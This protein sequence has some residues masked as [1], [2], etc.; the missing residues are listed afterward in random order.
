MTQQ[1]DTKHT[2]K[3]RLMYVEMEDGNVVDSLL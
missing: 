2:M 3:A 1:T